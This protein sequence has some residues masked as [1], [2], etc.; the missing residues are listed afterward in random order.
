MFECIM[1]WLNTV[2]EVNHITETLWTVVMT[3]NLPLG[4]QDQQLLYHQVYQ[5]HPGKE[6]KQ[7]F[8]FG[9]QTFSH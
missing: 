6:D 3:L 2:R 4:Q 5:M 8:I 7:Y 1:C 9:K